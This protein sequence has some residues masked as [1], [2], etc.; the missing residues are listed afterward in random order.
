MYAKKAFPVVTHMADEEALTP[1]EE[2]LW[3]YV[4]EYDFEGNPWSTPSA[5][6]E[7]GMEEQEVYDALSEVVK[8][9]KG[10]LYMYYKD[11]AIRLATE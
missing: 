3:K 9:K 10:E 5:A 7:L 8:K 2:K 4:K 6:K 1:V 11:G